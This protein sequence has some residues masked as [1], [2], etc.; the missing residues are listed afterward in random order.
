M[1]TEIA[2]RIAALAVSRYGADRDKVRLAC[3]AV[4]EFEA[5][6]KENDLIDLL[7]AQETLTPSQAE[8]LRR[9]LGGNG[10]SP[11]MDSS[12]ESEAVLEHSDTDEISFADNTLEEMFVPPTR[13]G[14]FLRG[15]G[16]FRLLRKLGE[17]GMGTVYLAY[18]E[19]AQRQIALK[20]LS[21][22]L[23]DNHAYVARFYREAKS[24]ALLDHP[25]IVRCIVADKDRT[26]DKHYFAMEYVDGPSARTLLEQ[27]GRLA[28][29]DAV[30][31]TLD[32]AHALE[33]AH[34]RNFVH[35]DIKPD[36]IL[37]TQTGVAKLADL[38][39]AK[40]ISDSSQLT[41]Q[42]HGF[43]TPYYMPCEQAMDATCA[44][45]RCDIYAL[46][47][48]MYHLVTGE[49]PFP[50]ETYLQIA[51]K[52]LA[53]TF[54]P[55]SAVN[56]AVPAVLDRILQKMLAR[57]PAD[58]YQTVSELIIDLERSRLDVVVPSFVDPVLAMQD[59]TV[60]A[61]LTAAEP[62]QLDVRS[63]V[64]QARKADG[65]SETWY[66]RHR[67]ADG[68]WC[69]T[70]ATTAQVLDRLREGKIAAD[71]EVSRQPQGEYRPLAAHGE[72]SDVLAEIGK[73]AASSSALS[74][75][76]EDL[77]AAPIQS[78]PPPKPSNRLAMVFTILLLL[79]LALGPTVIFFLL[80]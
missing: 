48:T 55:A 74:K 8:M 54:T 43:G 62:T 38:G 30:H 9:E 28:V 60:Q 14:H 7:V 64:A 2:R 51:E 45:A 71:T 27:F 25:H 6:G 22:R 34:A 32:I 13:S 50:G 73:K 79:L 20:V 66:L 61:R 76:V 40:W 77:L 26:S 78:S 16:K 4:L 46:G 53:G 18:D 23:A 33:Y 49:P 3:R 24:G 47:A 52:K 75:A 56:P 57:D 42:H 59:P 1:P 10:C 21:D 70:K 11:E 36:N 69:K 19:E 12:S 35:R 72:F 17:G 41:T 63:P 31:L 58:R 29:G 37:V 44:D 68:Q 15:L 80:Q 67:E 39:L 65:D 5:Q